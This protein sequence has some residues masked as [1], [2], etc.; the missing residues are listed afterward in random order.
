M[1]KENTSIR[2]KRIMHERNLKQIDIVRMAQ[3]Y[4]KKYGVKL[5]KPDISQYVSAK[6]E[7]GQDK[8][9]ILGMALNVSEAWLMGYDVPIERL[10]ASTNHKDTIMCHYNRLNDLGKQEATKRVEEL[11]H[12]DKYIDPSAPV[13]P[14][15]T[16]II[17]Y[18]YRLAS[19]GSGQIVFDT[20]PTKKIEIPDTPLN[21]RADYAIGVNG[22][23][24]EP[25]FFD[26]DMLLV[27]MTE[28]ISR[29]EIGI[30]LVDGES[31][32][33]KLGKD[34]LISLN[35]DYS[36]IPLDE[37]ARCLGRVIGKI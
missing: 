27:E 5:N 37:T 35:E 11:T 22:N 23:S 16:R 19:A 25:T 17:N 15:P 34:E 12:I 21:R 9:A 14:V 32:V 8:L 6:V 30:F 26:G 29:G 31:Y 2:L 3:P 7:P 28:E 36:N 24:M 10:S 20:P 13:P 33:K 1:N 4:C 18:Y